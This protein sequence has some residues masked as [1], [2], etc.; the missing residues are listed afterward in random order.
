MA[1]LP[2]PPRDVERIEVRPDQV[3]Q[4]DPRPWPNWNLEHELWRYIVLSAVIVA[5]GLTVFLILVRI[6]S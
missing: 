6:F 1:N 5:V 3:T 4:R 2:G